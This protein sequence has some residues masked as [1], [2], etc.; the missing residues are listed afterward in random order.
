MAEAHC[1]KHSQRHLTFRANPLRKR[2]EP[3][4]RIIPLDG[5]CEVGLSDKLG[6]PAIECETSARDTPTQVKRA[7]EETQN[8]SR[9]TR[10]A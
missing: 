2:R 7:D 9:K 1:T 4:T 8:R 3:V 5:A 6:V 10:M